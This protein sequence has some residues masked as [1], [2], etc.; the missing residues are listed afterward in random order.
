MTRGICVVAALAALWLSMAAASAAE[1]SVEEVASATARAANSVAPLTIVF[2][3]HAQDKSNLGTSL[4]AFEDW[5]RTRPQEPPLLNLYPQYV[6]PMVTKKT[7]RGPKSSPDKIAVYVAEARFTLPKAPK[8][9]DLDR[10]ATLAFAQGLDPAVT[11]Q[12]IK[13]G[14]VTPLTNPKFA[15]N[16][17]PAR[18][19]CVGIEGVCLRSHYRLEGK[20]PLGIALANKLREAD[21]KIVDYL[22]FE[23]ELAVRAPESFDRDA[24]TRLTRIDT[25]MIGA[26]EQ[27]TFY[28]NQ[29]LQFAKF[30]VVF[31]AHPSDPSKSVVTAFMLLA[32]EAKVL[33]MKKEYARVPVLRNLVPVQVLM[34]K[35]SFN[36]G[37]SISG[38]LP[39]YARSRIQTVARLLDAG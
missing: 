31:Q 28:V 12:I 4:L 15:N 22:E 13:P 37:H 2:N 38:G 21:K 24:M 9:H 6:E 34:G 18:P 30:L 3:D 29:V 25:P 8:L 11:H 16:L 5:K 10:F 36:T 33:D 20:L 17:N 35:S 26:I 27:T 1:Y 39:G 32:I 7:A 14:E 23:S 19:W